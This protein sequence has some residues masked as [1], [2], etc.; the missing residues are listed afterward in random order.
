VII[1]PSD[2][3][4]SLFRRYG[5][6]PRGGHFKQ[7]IIFTPDMVA[8]RATVNRPDSRSARK[9]REEYTSKHFTETTFGRKTR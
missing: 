4:V 6:K 7:R 2:I 5:R 9:F 3:Y 1:A 8:V